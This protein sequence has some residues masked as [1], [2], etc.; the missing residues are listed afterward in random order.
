MAAPV[1]IRCAG[2]RWV[3]ENHPDRPWNVKLR[4]GCECGAGAPCS[5]CNTPDD[6][7]L[8]VMPPGF[9]PGVKQ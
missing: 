3:C 4:N 7:E 1:C 8:P 9:V 6:A 2:V 5:L